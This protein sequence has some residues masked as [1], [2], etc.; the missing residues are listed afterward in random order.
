[1]TRCLGLDVATKCGFAYG[2]LTGRPCY[3][4]FKLPEL[5][6]GESDAIALASLYMGIITLVRENQIEVCAIEA[7]TPNIKRKN[8]R[9][10]ET[11]SSFRTRDSLLMMFGVA[12]AAVR[13]GGCKKIFVI[14]PSTWRKAVLGNGFPEKP[15]QAAIDYARLVFRVDLKDDN[16]ADAIG[17]WVWATGQSKLL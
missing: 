8:K 4:V 2:D 7:P 9:G 17:L 12:M 6:A 14:A 1:M 3:G 5:G 10:I 16:M 15:K 11:F 13:G